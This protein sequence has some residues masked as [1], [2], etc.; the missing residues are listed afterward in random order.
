MLKKLGFPLF[1]WIYEMCSESIKIKVVFIK[2][3][4][5][6]EW[7]INFFKLQDVIK[8]IENWAVLTKTEWNINFLQNIKCVEKKKKNEG[9][10][11]KN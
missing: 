6:N 9:V 10:F 5:N 2:T 7:N 11:T 1:L 8:S 3:E 4:M